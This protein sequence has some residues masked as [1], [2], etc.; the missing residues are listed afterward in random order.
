MEQFV[1][2]FYFNLKESMLKAQ[3]IPLSV[4]TGLNIVAH[5]TDLPFQ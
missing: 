3:H 1:I 2:L 4:G 5:G